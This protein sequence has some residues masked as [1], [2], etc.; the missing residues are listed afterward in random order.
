MRPTGDA[1]AGLKGF[2]RATA[3][4]V[5]RMFYEEGR[6]RFLV[7]D[8][9][10]LGK[11]MVARGV[12]ARTLERLIAKGIKRIDVV[13]ISSNAE[14]GRQNV[15][16][17]VPPGYDVFDR[18]DRLTLLPLHVKDLAG[19]D[20]PN[21]IAF[22]PG[23]MPDSGFRTG[24]SRE[25]ALI[26]VLLA[27]AWNLRLG[28]GAIR[29]LMQ[30]VRDEGRFR[31]EVADV[32]ARKPDDDIGKTFAKLVEEDP[33]NL[34]VAF[35]EL[36]R[37]LGRGQQLSETD[38]ERRLRLVAR[39]RLLLAR[40]CVEALEPD[41]VVLDEFQRFRHLLDEDTDVALL[42]R[43]I[44]EYADTDTGHH[45]KVLLLSATPYRMYTTREEDD[46]HYGDFV[47]TL[48]FLMDGSEGRA[49][50]AAALLERFRTEILR[51]DDSGA[52]LRARDDLAKTLRGVMVRTERL[53][54][55]SDRSGML[56]PSPR[57]GASLEAEDVQAYLD[58]D[59]ALSD[60]GER[61]GAA[62]IEYWKSAPYLPNLMD[63]YQLKKRLHAAAKTRPTSRALARRWRSNSGLLPFEAVRAYQ[64]I[65]AT[66]PRI[67]TLERDLLDTELWRVLW[68]APTLP[69][70]LPPEP[71]ARIHPLTKRLVF[72]SWRVA[73]RAIAVLTSYE[74]ERRMI[75]AS[76]SKPSNTPEG[77]VKLDR[78]LLDFKVAVGKSGRRTG[79]PALA[80][81]YPSVTLAEIDPLAH[82]RERARTGEPIPTLAETRA[83]ARARIAPLVDGLADSADGPVDERWYWAAPLVVD[84][85]LG[86]EWLGRRF[87]PTRWSDSG[88]ARW[89][90]HVALAA[91]A[92]AGRLDP[93]LGRQPDNLADVVADLA[94]AGPGVACLRALGRVL[95]RAW[96]TED[97]VRDAAARAA[98]GI[99][100]LLNHPES[101]TL[102]RARRQG[103]YWRRALTYCVEGGL[104]AVLDEFVHLAFDLH[105]VGRLAPEK[106]ADVVAE[107]IRNVTSARS[108]RIVPE[109]ITVN[110][111][112]ATFEPHS[113]RARFARAY[114]EATD[115]ET[116]EQTPAEAVRDAFNSPFAPFVLASTSVGQEGLDF[117]PY[118]HAVVH[119]NLPSNPVDL[120]QRE[121]RVHRYKGHALRK[122]VVA[123]VGEQSLL[124]DDDDPW[125]SVFIEAEA[126]E[127]ALTDSDIVPYWVFPGESKIERHVPA[128]PLS[129]DEERL[130]RLLRSLALY[131]SV[132]GQPRQEELVE[133]LSERGL[134]ADL[135]VEDLRIDLRPTRRGATRRRRPL[136]FPADA[137][138]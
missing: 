88:G 71:F 96:Q 108:S 118:C 10:G 98:W 57:R 119:W 110:G 22:T 48:R 91:E 40:A 116:G 42:F 113:M 105:A 76:E 122:N 123:A 14:I 132:L 8:E 102:I 54:V 5:D 70:Y 60:A 72:S 12:V 68:I 55:E 129:R 121:G 111:Q 33:G 36:S 104:Q 112:K 85:A 130:R 106:R 51:G 46:D 94:L 30:P 135:T 37:V 58:L 127:P 79:M 4:H 134:P 43:A 107:L 32:K 23:T 125:R 77:R 138:R 44:C 1:F 28:R 11:T 99:R 35:D 80:L 100:V 103:P 128:L 92:A 114:G 2:Q 81:M 18:L 124:R 50:K 56:D 136:P 131:R 95:G 120:E 52:L 83:W 133:L 89:P 15:R 65:P 78:R 90:E 47:R 34:R 74:A 7:A 29:L 38:R 9:V 26:Y 84:G 13:Y 6:S 39:L 97:H 31:A 64:P 126:S 16:R 63:A 21:F 137:S 20:R 25:R 49:S 87:L 69:Y 19:R 115:D 62:G 109:E 45:A 93:P 73:P 86:T 53:A 82:R 59:G 67:R 27:R 75:T 41:L 101:I 66:N 3:A 117:H 17:L 24:W 61:A